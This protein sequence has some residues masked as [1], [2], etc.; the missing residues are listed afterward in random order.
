MK[1]QKRKEIIFH[2]IKVN[3]NI[4]DNKFNNSQNNFNIRD[5]YN[6]SLETNSPNNSNVYSYY[7]NNNLIS[8]KCQKYKKKY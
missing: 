7:K 6:F 8:N 3:K 2:K 1:I 5:K 4:P